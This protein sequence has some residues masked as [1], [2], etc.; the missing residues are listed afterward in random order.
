MTPHVIDYPIIFFFGIL[1]NSQS[2]T[3]YKSLGIPIKNC[4]EVKLLTFVLLPQ[5]QIDPAGYKK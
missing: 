2:M 3:V 5:A 1:S 4:V